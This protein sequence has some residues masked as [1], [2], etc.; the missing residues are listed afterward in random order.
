[1]PDVAFGLSSL[2]LFQAQ[3]LAVIRFLA[4]ASLLALSGL[5]VRAQGE[6]IDC[7]KPLLV[8]EKTVCEEA[9]WQ[10]QFR[11][12]LLS[13]LYAA[14]LGEAGHESVLAGQVEWQIAR[15]SCETDVQCLMNLYENR[16]AL[17]AREAGDAAGVTGRYRFSKSE[18]AET[19]DA[20]VVRTPDGALSGIVTTAMAAAGCEVEFDGANPIGDAWI[21]DD[22]DSPAN[23]DT[24]CRI[25]FRPSQGSLRIDTDE[26]ND[27]C[28][29]GGYLDE[30]Y[31]KT[32]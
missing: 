22:P 15:D 32:K 14:L 1:V 11:D 7:A 23:S 18:N 31:V 5:P 6:A 3:G 26:C 19:G 28:R 4:T 12:G 24:F 20:Y 8:A 27:K 2:A 29:T 9:N 10:L 30:T 13:T 21:W 25:L 16:I 17:L